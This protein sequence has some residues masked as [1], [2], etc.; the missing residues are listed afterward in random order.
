[1]Q[2]SSHV[3]HKRKHI[4]IQHNE[5]SPGILFFQMLFLRGLFVE[6]LWVRKYGNPCVRENQFGFG[7]RTTGWST[8]RPYKSPPLHVCEFDK[9]HVTISRTQ[10]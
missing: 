5:I 2:K 8:G 4:E 9:Y 10:V 6:G 1:M 3:Q 7:H